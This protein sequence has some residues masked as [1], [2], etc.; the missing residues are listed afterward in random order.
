MDNAGLGTVCAL[1][2]VALLGWLLYFAERRER[3]DV[4]RRLEE[5]LHECSWEVD[6]VE[7]DDMHPFSL[8]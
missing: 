2:V 7:E 1:A 4:Q 8:N 6:D 5:F 3:R